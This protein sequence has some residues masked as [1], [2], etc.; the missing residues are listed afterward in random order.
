MAG[1]KSPETSEELKG[2]TGA[3]YSKSESIKKYKR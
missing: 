1:Y 3:M 2:L